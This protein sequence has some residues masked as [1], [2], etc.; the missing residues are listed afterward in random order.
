MSKTVQ[1]QAPVQAHGEE[2][3]TLTFREPTTKDVMEL[4]QCTLLIPSSDGTSVDIEVRTKLVGQYIVRLCGVPMST[5][6]SLSLQD[7]NRCQAVVMGFFGSGDGEE[8][9]TSSTDVSK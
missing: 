4:G 3:A 5:V 1:L 2:V 8:S 7:F 6:H 9:K